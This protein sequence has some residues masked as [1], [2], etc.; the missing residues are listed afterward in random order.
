MFKK[1]ERFIEKSGIA[2]TILE[3]NDSNNEVVFQIGHSFININADTLV[4]IMAKNG[5]RKEN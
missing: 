3:G 5:Y 4:S 1:G 2:I